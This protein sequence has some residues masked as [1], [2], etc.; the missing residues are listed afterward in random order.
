[1]SIKTKLTK[2]AL[3]LATIGALGAGSFLAAAPASA[4]ESRALVE[5]ES[6]TT[7]TVPYEWTGNTNNAFGDNRTVTLRIA[8]PL[9]FATGQNKLDRYYLNGGKWT[10][11]DSAAGMNCKLSNA[12]RTMTCTASSSA[13]QAVGRKYSYQ[14]KIIVPAGT[15][16]G[17]YNGTGTISGLG[18]AP[19]GQVKV[20]EPVVEEVVVA[21][22]GNGSV[23]AES[24]QTFTGTAEPNSTLEV[25]NAEG[26][27]IGTTTVL[28]NGTW[29]ATIAG[30][31]AP[32]SHG[33]TFSAAGSTAS[34]TYIVEEP[35]IE[36]AD[37]VVTSPATGA[38]IDKEDVVF[39]GTAEP[40]ATVV[41]TDSAGNVIGQGVANAQGGWTATVAGPLAEGT[42]DLTFTAG[43]KTAQGSYLVIEEEDSEGVPAI[44]PLYAGLGLGGVLIAGAAVFAI[45]RRTNA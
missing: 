9:E 2:G 33:L 8:A 17:T 30:T 19:A 23:I 12:N 39:A 10:I 28:A 25:K 15:P 20:V 1:M 35:V 27:V 45:R 31:L 3:A 14:P 44:D 34:G 37:L 41:I 29:S 22:P 24:G 36:I 26:V 5:A 16:V 21:T 13:L 38:T 43:D 18:F 40:G 32:G 42:H 6:G 7:V 4:A 11:L